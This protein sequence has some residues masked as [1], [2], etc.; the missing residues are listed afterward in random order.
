MSP[1]SI[2]LVGSGH[3]AWHLTQWMEGSSFRVR[4]IV[5][6]NIRR[7]KILFDKIRPDIVYVDNVSLLDQNSDIYIICTPDDVIES[8]VSKWPFTLNHN[9]ILVHCSGL[10]SSH[11]L[12]PAATHYGVF[13]PVQTLIKDIFNHYPP[14]IIYTAHQT[15]VENTLKN[16]AQCCSQ[17]YEKR[18]DE[19]REKIHLSAVIVNNF[20]HHLLVLTKEFCDAEHLDFSILHPIL[21][22]TVYKAMQHVSLQNTQT[23]PAVRNDVRTMK[24]HMELLENHNILK[25]IYPLISGSIQDKIQKS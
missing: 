10:K 2:S 5:S 24:R 1:K 15:D 12:K 9:Q 6:R 22:E 25:E 14:S 20:M 13:W 18:G 21:M 3:L 17:T 4:Q 23:G 19:D 8:I 16:M 11:I 7:D